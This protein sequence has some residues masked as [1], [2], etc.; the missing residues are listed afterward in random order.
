[1]TM[2][3]NPLQKLVDNR[4][5][6]RYSSVVPISSISLI[7][8]DTQGQILMEF[9]PIPDFCKIVCHKSP[10]RVCDHCLKCLKN[11]KG[12]R[13]VCEYGLENVYMPV[14]IEKEILGYI[15][16]IQAFSTETEYKKYLFDVSKLNKETGVS[17]EMIAKALAALATVDEKEIRIYEQICGHVANSIALDVKEKVL[18][19]NPDIERLSIEKELLERKIVDL[20]TKNNSLVINPHFL[21]NTLNSIARTAYFEHSHTTEELIYC[22]SDL[23]R[24][25]LKQ[26]NQLHT[27]EAEIDYIE[28][29]LYI[30]QVRFKDRLKY[31]IT[32]PDELRF[33]RILNMTLQPVVENALI[34]GITPKRDGGT[35][36]IYAE[37][38]GEDIL[39]NVE[40]DGN[41][42]PVD[43]LQSI[44]ERKED[45]MSLGFRSTDNRLKQHF[46]ASYGLDVRKS[47]YGGC[48]VAIKIPKNN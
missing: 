27:I 37:V 14:V 47:N 25:T 34:H 38:I 46:G 3:E 18:N 40:D 5:F 31:E 9:N 45:K 26:E 35:I 36:R 10:N 23:L 24:Y 8:I 48:I 2:K 43:V 21:F 17:S 7:L 44:R 11:E 19:E 33:E 6:S 22:L 30:Q 29:Y 42:F 39:I 28:K 20:E 16:G 15:I 1:M 4:L 41:G 32:I 13:Y 12:H